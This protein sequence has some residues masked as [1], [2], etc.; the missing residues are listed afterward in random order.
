MYEYRGVSLG[1][2][3]R[4]QGAND[5]DGDCGG[6]LGG[7]VDDGLPVVHLV[8]VAPNHQQEVCTKH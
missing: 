5:A 3:Q 2:E 8:V 1:I 7:V 6:S 4:P